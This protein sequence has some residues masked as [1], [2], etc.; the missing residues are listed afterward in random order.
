MYVKLVKVIKQAT[1]DDN[2][3]TLCTIMYCTSTTE[4]IDRIT[5]DS[6]GKNRETIF[7]Y[8]KN[9][10]NIVQNDYI[11]ID[12]YAMNLANASNSV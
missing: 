5:M 1:C 10:E 12:S 6:N 8:A 2:C 11:P 3:I 7:L 4:K 9:I